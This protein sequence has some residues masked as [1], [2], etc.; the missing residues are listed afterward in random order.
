MQRPIVTRVCGLVAFGLVILTVAAA[1]ATYLGTITSANPLG[2][3]RL[4]EASGT[5]AANQVSG[6]AAGTYSGFS[7]ADYGQT[8][9][10]T[11][12]GDTNAAA[13]FDGSDNFMTVPESV[14]AGI[15]TGAYSIE[16]WFNASDVTGR[17][18]MFNYKGGSV[19]MGFGV[20]GGKLQLLSN[21]PNVWLTGAP[22]VSTNT[23]YH[24]AITRDS[25]SKLTGYLNGAE[26]FSTNNSTASFGSLGSA[27]WFGANNGSGTPAVA[28]AGSLDEVAIYGYQLTG[29][30]IV[31]HYNAGITP[32]PEPASVVLL[33][34]G[35]LGLLA[36]AWRKR[37]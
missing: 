5:T 17:H 21:P 20:Q 18:D 22:T 8:G 32:V 25:A 33:G 35:L 9:A 14:V 37:K 1:Q 10:L 2:Y 7:S 3:W 6:G 34:C 36:Y 28:F 12:S 15:T 13:G 19:D 24:V 30:Q 4:D 11:L 29:D 27:L 26:I 16:M 31:A 23:W